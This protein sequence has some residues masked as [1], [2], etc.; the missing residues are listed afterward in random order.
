[1]KRVLVTGAT[2]F[3]GRQALE[4]L[5]ERGFE[6]HAIARRP[7]PETDVTWH[8][9]DL[10]DAPQ[11][12][13]IIS[14][15][16]STH[17]LHLAWYAVH[18][19]YWRSPENLR[20]VEA[21]SRL[22]RAFRD[23]GGS[24][25]V[26]AGTCAEYDWD[27][28]LCREDITPLRPQTLYGVSKDALHRIVAAYGAEVG[29][30]VAWGR[31]F[32]SYGPH[33]DPNRLVASVIRS[34]L[35]DEPA[36]VT[37]GGQARDFLHVADVGSAFAALVDRDVD[38]PVNIASGEARPVREIVETI[39]EVVGRPGLL[40]FGAVPTPAGESPLVAADV[41]RLRDE[42]SWRPQRTLADGLAE[43]V[44]WW[45]GFDASAC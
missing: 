23:A 24:R 13:H 1:V 43:T 16:G 36:A 35:A 38:G 2:G 30:S 7:Q 37:E 12:E 6:I 42:V 3:V 15:I 14:E 18:G 25:A 27:S 44:D 45:R 22:V 39:G 9:I 40:R 26:I 11:L 19:S 17:L 10:L 21:S 5:R 41:G 8:A 33:E 29:L 31:I 4:P 28:G 34:L 20:W 32:F